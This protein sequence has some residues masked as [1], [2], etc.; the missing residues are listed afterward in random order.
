MEDAI[1][2]ETALQDGTRLTKIL[3]TK[4]PVQMAHGRKGTLVLRTERS[5]IVCGLPVLD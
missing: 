4:D 3:C 5:D 2:V 1:F